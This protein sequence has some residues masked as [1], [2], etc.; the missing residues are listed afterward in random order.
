MPRRGR[1]GY[2]DP[3]TISGF[4]RLMNMYRSLFFLLLFA[5]AVLTVAH[6]DIVE[7]VRISMGSGAFTVAESQLNSYRAQKGVTAEYV[8]A[9]SWMARG[10]LK[11]NKLDQADSFAH[12]TEQLVLPILAKRKLDA[13][14]R[15]PTALGAA[16]E[17][18]AQVLAAR[19]TPA[20]AVALLQRNIRTYRNTSIRNRLQKNLNLLALVGKPAP[21]L[22]LTEYLGPKP[23]PLAQLKGSPVLLFFWAHW[24]GD[25]KGE[26]PI[27]ARLHS[28]YAGKG[29]AVIAPTQRYGYAAQGQ[30]ATPAAELAYIKDVRAH[31]YA[32]LADVPAPLSQENLSVYGVSTTPTLVVLDRA[33]K[34]TFY[35]PGA[36]SYEELKAVIDRVI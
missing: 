3:V 29:L 22:H 7:D 10:Y 26:V 8:E 17:V 24:C 18:Q 32:A 16:I 5:A 4:D 20:Q 21:A 27:I 9:S 33:G 23:L 6:A 15:L 14:P 19:G 1:L 28:E 12:K 2:A 36:L 34:V 31:Y 13:E 30:D 11:A 35:H 25:C